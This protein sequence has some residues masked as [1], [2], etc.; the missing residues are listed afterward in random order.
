M[1]FKI[2]Y[3]NILH[4][5]VEAIVN[6]ANE[7][8]TVGKGFDCDV[9][10]AAGYFELLNYRSEFIDFVEEGNVFITP[11]FAL[12]VK[13]IIH[14]VCP[15]YRAG[16]RGT[17]TK[18]RSCYRKS[19]RIAKFNGIR[20][21][22]FPVLATGEY[23]Y[24]EDEARRIAL[25]EI[26]SF[27][28]DNDMDIYLSVMKKPIFRQPNAADIPALRTLIRDSEA[29]WG[30][31]EEF[32]Q[33]F[34]EIY[35]V[36]EEFIKKHTSFVMMDNDKLVGFWGMTIIGQREGK[37]AEL[38]FFYVD[39]KQIRKGYGKQLWKHMIDWCEPKDIKR[40]DFVTSE[41]A[42]EFYKKCGAVPDSTN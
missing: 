20:S 39:S 3:D 29:V 14:A 15:V 5:K 17:E 38:E 19:L 24:P 42:V 36:T 31:N 32:L 34:D 30:F 40:I 41:P 23:G 21:I 22:A 28:K 1:A 6:M 4:M 12:P 2:V 16:K 13:F 8:P 7:E 9:Y 35:N 33:T 25:E 10:Q 26:N 18:L 37:R 27:L 11:G